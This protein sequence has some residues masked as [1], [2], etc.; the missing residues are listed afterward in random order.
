L[1]VQQDQIHVAALQHFDRPGAVGRFEHLE[2]LTVTDLAQQH[3]DL[4]IVIDEEQPWP[5]RAG[6]IVSHEVEHLIYRLGSVLPAWVP[7][8]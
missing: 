6:G 1:E 2:A 7:G 3:P 4:R 5:R 8:D